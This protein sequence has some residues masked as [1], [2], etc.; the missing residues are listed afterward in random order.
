MGLAIG[1]AAAIA[2]AHS[3]SSLLYGVRP[4]DG[5][6]FGGVS[7]ALFSVAL[8]AGWLPAVRAARVDPMQALRQE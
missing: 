2:L 3:L 8:L 7:A 1:C 4:I 5:L 6:T